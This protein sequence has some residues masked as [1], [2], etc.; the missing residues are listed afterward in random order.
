MQLG[1]GGGILEETPWL[2]KK[3]HLFLKTFFVGTNS[4]NSRNSQ[5]FFLNQPLKYFN[6]QS[7]N[8]NNNN[9]KRIIHM[10]KIN[11]PFSILTRCARECE[12]NTSLNQCK[13]E[14]S[15]QK[16]HYTNFFLI[17]IFKN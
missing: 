8:Y 6:I 11:T 13:I 5:C 17:L 15:R 4:C 16:L 7:E 10:L 14:L 2:L 9:K 3:F 12:K 1:G